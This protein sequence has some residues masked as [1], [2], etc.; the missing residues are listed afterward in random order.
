MTIAKVA[1]HN[2]L[3]R[4]AVAWAPGCPSITKSAGIRGGFA[5]AHAA[6]KNANTNADGGKEV[7]GGRPICALPIE[8]SKI[9]NQWEERLVFLPEW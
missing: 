1:T 5:D 3:L 8:L 4:P 7:R 6:K 9:R 2:R